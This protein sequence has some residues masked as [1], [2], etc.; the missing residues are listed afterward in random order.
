[1]KSMRTISWCVVFLAVCV[2]FA[3]VTFGA[4]AVR[5][6]TKDSIRIG[7]SAP[8]SKVLANAGRQSVEATKAYTNYINDQGG[9]HGRKIVLVVDDSQLDPS[10]SLGIFKKQVTNDNIFA[11]ISWGAPPSFVLIKPAEEEKIPLLIDAAVKPFFNPPKKYAFCFSTPFELTAAACIT[12]IH[13]V[14]KKKDARIAVFWRN[15]DYGKPILQGVK[16]AAKFYKYDVVAEPSYILGQTIDFTSEVMKIRRANA[17][18]V[19]LGSSVGDVANFLREAKNQG[20]KAMVFGGAPPASEQKIISQAGDAAENYMATFQTSMFRETSIPG[21]K[22]MLD[23]SKKYASEDILKEES[24]YYTTLY[25][26]IEYDVEALK[27]AGPNPTQESFVKALETAGKTFDGGGLGPKI[28]FSPTK[29]YSSDACFLGQVDMKVKDF[30][31]IG[32]W[33]APPKDLIDKLLK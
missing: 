27:L 30:R 24:F 9:I 32:D 23:I 7:M 12:Y 26:H 10:I 5:G 15:D 2:C 16:E 13:D 31:R 25:D 17:D 14:L 19:I 4:E 21:V 1:M 3:S 33:I 11:H 6:V 8:L 18:Y 28:T 29:R 22:K 20:L